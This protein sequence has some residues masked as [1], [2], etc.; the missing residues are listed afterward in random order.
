MTTESQQEPE[1]TEKAEGLGGICP[2]DEY[3]V[4]GRE[5]R[6]L[7]KAAKW[8]VKPEYREAILNRQV[9]TAIDPNSSPRDSA[10][11][12]R[13]VLDCDKHEAEQAN[14]QKGTT[15]AIQ[16]NVSTDRDSGGHVSRSEV[17]RNVI[18]SNPDYLDYVRSRTLAEDSD[19]G[20]LREDGQRGTLEDGP[21]SRG[22]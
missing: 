5:E 2:S 10:R 17:V 1:T 7:A 18:N 19:A 15:I 8:N 13:F 9:R 4:I 20:T 3:P 11:A 14:P 6:L 12:A 22:T 16:N 21:P